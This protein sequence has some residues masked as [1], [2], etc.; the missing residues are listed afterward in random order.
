LL[1]IFILIFDH[2]VTKSQGHGDFG[3]HLKIVISRVI[4]ISDGINSSVLCPRFIAHVRRATRLALVK[5]AAVDRVSG[6]VA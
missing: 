5:A 6:S 1:V 2:N 4:T 3:A